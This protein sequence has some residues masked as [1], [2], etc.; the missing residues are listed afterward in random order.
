MS[1]NSL[2]P[3]RPPRS[4]VS[5]TLAVVVLLVVAGV[6]VAG[7]AAYYELNPKSPSPGP[8]SVTVVDDLGRTVVAPIDPTRVV[9]LAPSIMDIVYRLGL[10]SDVVAV[11][12]TPSIVGGILDEYSFNQ[13]VLWNL[14]NSDCVTDF[15]SLNTEGVAALSAQLVLA[16]TLTSAQ[17]VAT[18]TQTYGIPVV[19]LAPSTLE[20]VVGD[21]RIVSSIFPEAATTATALVS[22]LA[23]S[24]SNASAY[25]QNLSESGFTS[26]SVLL[27]YYFDSGGYYSYS[28]G[29]FGDS[30]ISFAGGTNVAAGIAVV[31]GEVNASYVFDQQ[32]DLIIYPTS[33]NDPYLVDDE[34][35]A[36]WNGSA[37]YWSQLAGAKVG[38]DVTI[39]TEADPT[40]IL[41]L[42]ALQAI[43][44]ASSGS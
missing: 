8:N 30:L 3:K 4:S 32:P 36:V 6:A 26:P 41:A 24:L 10:R 38:V 37:P 22:N 33:W 42:P 34:T 25:V 12:C 44:L 23:Q 9:V 2:P 29:S 40:M 39:L 7:T 28:A 19:L 27:T 21:V 43:V 15:P 18:L 17:D 31:Y 14:T 35:P 13:T 1:L 11:G 20:G 16:S 5:L